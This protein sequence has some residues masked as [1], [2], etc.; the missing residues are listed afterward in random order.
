MKSIDILQALSFNIDFTLVKGS[1]KN[2]KSNTQ[3]NMRD[4]AGRT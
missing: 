3:L 1:F 4:L 2:V